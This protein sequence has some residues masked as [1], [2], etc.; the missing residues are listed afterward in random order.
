[1][2]ISQH[3]RGDPLKVEVLVGSEG[4]DL[5]GVLLVHDDEDVAVAAPHHLLCLPKQTSLFYVE[6]LVLNAFLFLRHYSETQ[7]IIIT[8]MLKIN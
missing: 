3:E 4:K 1:L 2:H 8:L 6:L 7:I 5:V